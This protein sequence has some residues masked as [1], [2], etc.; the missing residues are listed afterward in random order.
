[1]IVLNVDSAAGGLSLKRFRV[2]DPKQPYLLPPD[3]TEW[4]PD[5]HLAFFVHELVQHLDLSSIYQDYTPGVGGRPPLEP[6]MIVS[7]SIY[8]YATGSRSSRKDQAAWVED[9]AVRFLAGDQ[10]QAC[11]AVNRYS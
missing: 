4:L 3:P 9:V 6:R 11:E 5:G 10:Q 1:M 7:V 2:Y 8:A